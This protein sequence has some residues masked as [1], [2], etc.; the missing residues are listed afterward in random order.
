MLTLLKP[1]LLGGD[2]VS[3]HFAHR[4]QRMIST[5]GRNA[6]GW[7]G[8]RASIGDCIEF[9]E[10]VEDVESVELSLRSLGTV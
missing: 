2:T 10:S 5:V 8:D 6:R 9:S 4:L 1:S 7:I 3:T